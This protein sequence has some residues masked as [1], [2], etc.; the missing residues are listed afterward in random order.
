M[1]YFKIQNRISLFSILRIY[2]F[3]KRLMLLKRFQKQF[4]FLSLILLIFKIYPK[5]TC[6]L[7]CIKKKY[8][9]I[10]YFFVLFKKYL[11]SGS[12]KYL[13]LHKF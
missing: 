8:F 2:V 11:K 9:K 10:K 4:V 12:L 7:F 5:N 3:Q 13:I 6:Y 1:F